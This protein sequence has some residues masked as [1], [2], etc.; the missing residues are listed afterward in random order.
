MRL[1]V[2]YGHQLFMYNNG[3]GYG[4]SVWEI[5]KTNC[6]CTNGVI[7]T[8]QESPNISEF[9]SHV[10]IRRKDTSSSW[11]VNNIKNLWA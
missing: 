10:Y 7:S 5:W 1:Q 3:G 11:A 6:V 2:P 9:G 8:K 4:D